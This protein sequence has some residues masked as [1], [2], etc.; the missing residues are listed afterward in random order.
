MYTIQ[1]ENSSR[2]ITTS[3]KTVVGDIMLVVEE[4]S[5]CGHYLLHTHDNLVSLTNPD[6]TWDKESN[7]EVEILNEGESI[8]LTVVK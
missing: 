1:R 3:D 5:Y 4:G 2:I 8:T 7:F 6:F